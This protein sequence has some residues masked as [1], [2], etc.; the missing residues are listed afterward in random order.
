MTYVLELPGR[1][2]TINAERQGSRHWTSTRALT[3]GYRATTKILWRDGVAR[4]VYPRHLDRIAVT[5]RQ[6][7]TDGRWHQDIGAC[8]PAVKAAID[9]LVDAGL[10]PDDTPEYVVS[11]TF[12]PVRVVGR[13]ALELTVEAAP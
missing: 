11:L 13:D 1:P 7:A 6:L 8:M 4:K 3:R 10:V 2:P 12:L 9:G 5:A